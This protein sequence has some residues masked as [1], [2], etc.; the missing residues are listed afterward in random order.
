[1]AGIDK[2]KGAVLRCVS[3]LD[4][5]PEENNLI[6]VI[7][8]QAGVLAMT[9]PED[10]D[11]TD[12]EISTV[13]RHIEATFGIRMDLGTSFEGEDYRPWLSPKHGEIEWHYWERYKESLLQQSFP[14]HVVRSLDTVTD[15]ILDRTEDPEKEGEW[16]RKGMVV[17]HVQ[18]GKT[19]NYN[20]LICK[21]ADAGYKVIIVLAGL[22]NS[23][24]NQTQQ[25]INNDFIGYCISAQAP[26]GVGCLGMDK[27]G[28]ARPVS[29][30]TK[31]SDFNKKVATQIGIELGALK[32]PVIF[33]LK[34]NKSTLENL[35]DWLVANN[36]YKLGDYPMLLIDDE[37]DH[38]SVNTR[39]EGNEPTTINRCIRDLLILFKKKSYVGYTATPFANIFIDP[40]NE[41]E[42]TNGKI[43]GDLFPRDFIL[44][45][46]PPDNYVGPLSVFGRESASS[47]L[48]DITDNGDLLPIRHKID[49]PLEA[50]PGSLKEAIKCFILARAV[51][52]TR[53][54]L[55]FHSSMMVN[56][57][58]FTNIQNRLADLIY[59]Y[60]NEIKQASSNYASLGV[61]EALKNSTLSSL[62]NTWEK[63]FKHI[64]TDWKEIQHVLKEAADPVEILRI[65][66]GGDKLDYDR[67]EFPDGRTVI[68]VGGI[69]LS[70][71]LTLEGL[72]TSYFLRNSVMYDTLMQMGRWFGYRDG[73]N[74]LCRVFMTPTAS[75]WYA[76]VAVVMEELRSDFRVM[77]KAK[78]TPRDFGLRVRSHPAALIVTARNKMRSA[79]TVPVQI[80]LEG[81]LVETTIISGQK[82]HIDENRSAFEKLIRKLEEKCESQ[83][84]NE[85]SPYGTYWKSVPSEFIKNTVG[86]LHNHPEC[87]I[88]DHEPLINYI[89]LLESDGVTTFDVI[90]KSLDGFEREIAGV[91]YTPE[92]RT[93]EGK[94]NSDRIA[95]RNRRIGSRGDEKVGLSDSEV[96]KIE[97]KYGRGNTPDKLY[98]KTEGK[99]PL[100]ILHLLDLKDS[101]DGEVI[102]KDVPAYG[103]SFPG[104]SGDLRHPERLVE[105]MVNTTWWAKNYGEEVEEE[106]GE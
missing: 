104:D 96:E 51:R 21:A 10:S 68:A 66:S 105:Y 29:L 97:K 20:G 78:L 6:K 34:K 40:E 26:I 89:E 35:Y 56:A 11:Y 4:E 12:E 15:N 47:H 32:A 24:R 37:A 99:N 39:K 59:P 90:L 64:D 101:E 8:A 80:G 77:E 82:K 22:I 74:D 33:V 72:T 13:S 18:S 84:L 49:H 44:C 48:R 53:G 93:I 41:D 69:G 85:R 106:E 28:R 54:H 50:M 76:H 94:L 98:R 81:R 5:L 91:K 67:N 17:G 86:S 55:G 25:R 88:T 46:D 73:Y 57:S 83:Q 42:M 92:K 31:E 3:D 70:R 79:R 9:S 14:P 30:T 52:I 43:Y 61:V 60:V 65:N 95:F 102:L 103:I 38:A 71:G 58:R 1:M 27:P 87:L 19:A 2:L 45:L 16:S 36:D 7:Q 75:S 100:M 62:H 23:L 63:E